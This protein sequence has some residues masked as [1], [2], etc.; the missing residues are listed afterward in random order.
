M[1]KKRTIKDIEEIF[2]KCNMV[3]WSNNMV[4][5]CKQIGIDD[6]RKLYHDTIEIGFKQPHP[7]DRTIVRLET[8][9]KKW[10]AHTRQYGCSGQLCRDTPND[11]A[12]AILEEHGF[13][14]GETK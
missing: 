7:N 5:I 14:K 1:T 9:N 8:K 10:I 2:E 4:K 12:K 3:T 11:L 13:F 6:T